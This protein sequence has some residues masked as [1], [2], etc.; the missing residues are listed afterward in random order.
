MPA[1]SKKQQHF[2][3]L[4]SSAQKGKLKHPSKEVEKAAK[5]MSKK[6][7]K[8]FA[9][10]KT[11]GLPTKVK[12][13][14]K[15]IV[16]EN[17]ENTVGKLYVV[18]KPK[19]GAP[20]EEIIHEIDPV[21]GAAHHG[22][23]HQTI[24]GVYKTENEARKASDKVKEMHSEGMKKLDEK[25]DTVASKLTKKIEALDKKRAAH[26]KN[27]EYDKEDEVAKQIEH[28]KNN[29]RKIEKSKGEKEEPKKKALKESEGDDMSKFL[30]LLKQHDWYYMMGSEN[31]YAE[32]RKEQAEIAKYMKTLGPKAEEAFKKAYLENFP[33]ADADLKISNLKKGMY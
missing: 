25:K 4:V 13:A 7:V 20:E 29:L 11:K 21:M 24:H 28:F 30:Q 5:T 22:L 32:G 14:K 3:G 19:A 26:F 27:K 18:V 1:V 8:D 12:P 17:Y 2:M 23:D 33:K 16:K 10:T 31:A 15:S 6:S 9:S